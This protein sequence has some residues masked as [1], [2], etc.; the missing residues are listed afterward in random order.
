MSVWTKTVTI[1]G[2]EFQVVTGVFNCGVLVPPS[3]NLDDQKYIHAMRL[4]Q[5]AA[6]TLD[7]YE[8]LY[9]QTSQTMSE[10]HIEDHELYEDYLMIKNA[11]ST[12][13]LGLDMDA[14]KTR[15]IYRPETRAR[16]PEESKRK[17]TPGYVY[18]LKSEA[19]RR[20]IGRTTNPAQ[21]LK[22]F[23]VLLPMIVEYELLL[24]SSEH[25]LLEKQLHKRFDDFR[26][27]GEWFG[28]TDEMVSSLRGEFAAL[29]A[30][31]SENV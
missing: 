30:E 14:I 7:T 13:L 27:E 20:K 15:M 26:I 28:L 21:R 19:G 3:A 25:Q 11:K 29:I 12:E 16:Q 10:W 22:N 18:I 1:N 8:R 24:K 17:L 5:F 2:Y 4:A 9:F 23:G 6:D 31:D